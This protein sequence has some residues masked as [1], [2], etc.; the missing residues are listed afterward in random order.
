ML[1]KVMFLHV[2]S[3]HF[4]DFNFRHLTFRDLMSGQMLHSFLIA[5]LRSVVICSIDMSAIHRERPCFFLFFFSFNISN[6]AKMY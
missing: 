4:A 2:I 3:Y 1:K 5:I 6:S